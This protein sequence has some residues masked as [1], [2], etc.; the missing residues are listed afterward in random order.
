MVARAIG[1]PAV[2]IRLVPTV[3]GTT[4]GKVGVVWTLQEGIWKA[5]RHT[6]ALRGM[7]RPRGVCVASAMSGLRM[8]TSPRLI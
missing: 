7:Q 6:Y 8:P 4:A 5:L 1:L 2:C 3:G